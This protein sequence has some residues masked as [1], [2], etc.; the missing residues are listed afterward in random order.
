MQGKAETEAFV[1]H[2]LAI[3]SMAAYYSRIIDDAT[4]DKAPKPDRVIG[5]LIGNTENNRTDIREIMT[6]PYRLKGKTLDLDDGGGEETWNDYISDG[7]DMK[8]FE[9]CRNLV[10]EVNGHSDIH[11]PDKSPSTGIAAEQSNKTRVLGWF[12]YG[13]EQTASTNLAVGS[14]LKKR[15]KA[16]RFFFVSVKDD[17]PD[18]SEVL[19]IALYEDKGASFTKMK[20]KVEAD[21]AEGVAM[22]HVEKMNA[23]NNGEAPMV[24]KFIEI[25]NAL[26]KLQNRIE[27]IKQF[28]LEAKSA[29]SSGKPLKRALLRKV[30]RVLNQL[31]GADSG[32]AD[33]VFMQN[34]NNAQLV[35][36]LSV[37]TK[38]AAS[39]AT[40]LQKTK[41]VS[42]GGRGGGMH[43][44]DDYD[45]DA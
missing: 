33:N 14:I 35:T 18:N 30:A 17:I 2:P 15:L 45:F 29:S 3:V 44:F 32:S 21:I 37:A 26:S 8:V 1:L 34:Y 24:G 40:V 28:L 22:G 38:M 12:S 25:Q 7:S 6:F 42:G 43:D 11:E 9:S 19:P 5:C 4:I 41:V 20:F 27:V 31:P 36:Y 10:L 16:N 39:M 13:K 23:R